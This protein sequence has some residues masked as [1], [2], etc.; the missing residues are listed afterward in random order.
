MKDYETKLK[1]ARNGFVYN[2]RLKLARFFRKLANF[3]SPDNFGW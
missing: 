2:V 1:N 3:V